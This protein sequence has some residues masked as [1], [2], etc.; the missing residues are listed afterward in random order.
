MSTRELKTTRL[1]LPKSMDAI[2][3]L[4]KRVLA[5]PFVASFEVSAENG[6]VISRSVEPGEPVL[7]EG[8]DL[9]DLG[10]EFLRDRFMT[11]QLE[12]R[13]PE[14]V[15]DEHPFHRL[16]RATQLLAD[17]RLVV[18]C[19]LVPSVE[20]FAAFLGFDRGTDLGAPPMLFGVPV[21]GLESE[22]DKVVVVGGAT[23]DPSQA[24]VG[25]L[26]EVGD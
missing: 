5:L 17:E 4:V 14:F 23:A 9:G 8:V 24:A 15:P 11:Q 10:P 6:I 16:A 20:L 13:Q 7:P 19:Y 18:I 26:V 2:E 3:A 1:P 22:S 21:Y 12:L 25:I